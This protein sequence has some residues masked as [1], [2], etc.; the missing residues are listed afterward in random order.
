MSTVAPVE[1][2]PMRAWMPS[3]VVAALGWGSSFLF[4]KMGLEAFTPAQVGFGRLAV[5]AV[6]LVGMVALSR[7]WPR[8][9]LK[10]VGAISV[11]AVCMSGVPMVLIPMA[12][13]HI[14][15]ILASLLNATTPLWTA[16]FV[17]LL[18]PAERT[19]RAQLV[20]LLVGAA[21]IAVLVGAWDVSEF[22]L[23]GTVLMLTA[24]AF[25][26][27]GGTLSR[28]LLTRVSA[29]PAGLSMTQVGVSAVMLAPVAVFSGAPEPGAFSLTGA[30]LWGLL[31]LGVLG[32]SFAYVMFWKVVKLAGATAATSVTFL[33]PV[34]A[35]V[36]GVTI[37]GEGLQWYEPVG[38]AVVFV[39]VWLAG[40]TRPKRIPPPAA[41]PPGAPSVDVA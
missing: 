26:G 28:M 1:H 22:S 3:L 35:T 36:L 34:V 9:T 10:Q 7:R 38:A 32:T 41:T 40:R 13:Q 25:Y 5:G 21:G 12:E 19:T 30:P 16:L 27:I 23:S 15:S 24:T 11:V 37:L 20:G 18:I 4:I 39:G 17:A 2:A 6:V 33:V 31:A 8:L 14:T 29:G